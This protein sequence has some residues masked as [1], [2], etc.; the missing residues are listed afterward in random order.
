MHCPTYLTFVYF[1]F[2]HSLTE[3]LHLL[4]CLCRA[5]YSDVSSDEFH[6]RE[7]RASLEINSER[8]QNVHIMRRVVHLLLK[9]GVEPSIRVPKGLVGPVDLLC[10]RFESSSFSFLFFFEEVRSGCNLFKVVLIKSYTDF[11]ES[12]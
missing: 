11:S 8:R 4:I 12:L 5:E 10:K 6:L 7:H 2:F 3:F 1:Y 9:G